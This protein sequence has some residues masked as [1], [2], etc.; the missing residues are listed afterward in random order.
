MLWMQTIIFIIIAI[1]IRGPKPDALLLASGEAP[2]IPSLTSQ[3]KI[4]KTQ[5]ICQIYK[6]WIMYIVN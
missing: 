6:K 2:I 1:M 3:K 4:A 5:Q